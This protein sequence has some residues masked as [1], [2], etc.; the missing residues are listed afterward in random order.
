MSKWKHDI[1]VNGKLKYDSIILSDSDM[2]T[3]FAQVSILRQ[4]GVDINLYIVGR[5]LNYEVTKYEVWRKYPD[6]IILNVFTKLKG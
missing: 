2:I 1:Y 6:R 5:D 4:E 3:R